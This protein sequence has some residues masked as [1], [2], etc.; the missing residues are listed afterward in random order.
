FENSSNEELHN[1]VMDHFSSYREALILNSNPNTIERALETGD[2]VFLKKD[3]DNN[4]TNR[5]QAFDSFFEKDKYMFLI[6]LIII[7]RHPLLLVNKK[8]SIKTNF[9]NDS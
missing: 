8:I 9:N 1:Q 4:T 6:C 3:F 5:Y 2:F 7:I